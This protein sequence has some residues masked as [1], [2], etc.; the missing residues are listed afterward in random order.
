M[1]NI[2]RET[3]YL[4]QNNGQMSK[5]LKFEIYK[6]AIEGQHAKTFSVS[7]ETDFLVRRFQFRSV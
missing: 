3:R 6:N 7:D 2:L 4:M 1:E 5:K